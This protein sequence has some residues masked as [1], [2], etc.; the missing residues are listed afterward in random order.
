MESTYFGAGR[1]PRA[2]ASPSVSSEA[3]KVDPTPHIYTAYSDDPGSA[4]EFEEFK[5]DESAHLK[6][7]YC[8]DMLNEGIQVAYASQ[9]PR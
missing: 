3:A 6:L 1:I 8:I 9:I 7:L 5:K 2:T 4:R